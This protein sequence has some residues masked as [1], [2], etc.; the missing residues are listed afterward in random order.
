MCGSPILA[1]SAIGPVA[2][3][4]YCTPPSTIC[5][6]DSNRDAVAVRRALIIARFSQMLADKVGHGP[7]RGN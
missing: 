7:C 4:F 3:L 1:R 5:T 6:A 2:K